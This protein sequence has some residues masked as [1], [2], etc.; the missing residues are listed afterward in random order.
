MNWKKWKKAANQPDLYR[1]NKEMENDEL[2]KILKM[3]KI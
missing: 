3:L 2:D 1:K